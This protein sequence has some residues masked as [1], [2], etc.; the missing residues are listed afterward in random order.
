MY[1]MMG[2][3]RV[4]GMMPENSVKRAIKQGWIVDETSQKVEMPDVIINMM[5]TKGLTDD[6][7]SNG[8][9]IGIDDNVATVEEIKSTTNSIPKPSAKADMNKVLREKQTKK[10]SNGSKE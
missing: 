8:D 5:K 7:G 2:G 9:T 3:E 6:T 1:K 4:Y 10:N